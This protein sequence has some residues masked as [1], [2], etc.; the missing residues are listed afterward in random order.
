[1]WPFT[2]YSRHEAHYPPALDDFWKIAL[3]RQGRRLYRRRFGIETSYW[4]VGQVRGWTTFLAMN[5][6]STESLA[7]FPSHTTA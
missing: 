4:R 1:M 6:G 7:P 3:S 5:F 2:P